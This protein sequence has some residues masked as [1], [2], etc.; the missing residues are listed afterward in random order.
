ML[1][2][3]SLFFFSFSCTLP[4][5]GATLSL[6]PQSGAFNVGDTI[7]VKLFIDTKGQKIFNVD[8]V[9]NYDFDRLELAQCK[10]RIIFLSCT[11]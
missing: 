8:A 11:L 6:Q 5:G 2:L 1:P 9:F 7:A 10:Q 3:S 4:V